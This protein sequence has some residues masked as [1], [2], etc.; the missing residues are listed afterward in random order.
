M[1]TRNLP[2]SHSLRLPKFFHK[3]L[4]LAF[5]FKMEECARMSGDYYHH[6]ASEFF[7]SS[8]LQVLS[9]NGQ[10]LTAII[11]LQPRDSRHS[12]IAFAFL[13]FFFSLHVC[14]CVWR[15]VGWEGFRIA[16]HYITRGQRQRTAR[17]HS[18]TCIFSSIY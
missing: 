5:F 2:K 13:A 10:A 17:L 9:D 12:C 1:S 8:T 4:L 15:M 18:H 16:L 7:S 6:H 11:F 3:S 14:M